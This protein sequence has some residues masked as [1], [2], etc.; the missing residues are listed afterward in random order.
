MVHRLQ[1]RIA[2]DRLSV[3]RIHTFLS[4]DNPDFDAAIDLAVNGVALCT[5]ATYTGCGWTERPSLSPAFHKTAPAIEKMMYDAYWKE[6]LSIVL[7]SKHVQ[8]IPSLGLCLAGWATKLGKKYGRP[9]TNG[10]GRPNMLD[11]DFINGPETKENAKARY[12]PIKNPTIGDVACL[13]VEAGRKRGVDI[14]DLSIWP[15]DIHAAYLQ[16]SN[17]VDESVSNYARA[18][19]CFSWQECSGSHQCPSP[20]T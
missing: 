4:P 6:G 15:F 3:A 17:A 5:P 13:I 1:D 18:P 16:L 10:S 2:H 20:L 11:N 7:T 14:C 9:I 12:G 8:E 19:S